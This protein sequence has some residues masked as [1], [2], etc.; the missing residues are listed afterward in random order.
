MPERR[1]VTPEPI[2][3]IYFHKGMNSKRDGVNIDDGEVQ[4]AI[5]VTF[6]NPS[7]I[8]AI[9]TREA[10]STN[11]SITFH[12]LFRHLNW[13][14]ALSTDKLYYQWDLDGYCNRYVQPN[15]E[16]TLAGTIDSP[17]QASCVGYQ[18]FIFIANGTKMQAFTDGNVYD[19]QFINPTTAST[20]ANAGGGAIN[21][22]VGAMTGYYT[23]LIKYP[24]GHV[25]ETAPS[26]ASNALTSVS[27]YSINWTNIGIYPTIK[28]PTGCVVHR[29]LYRYNASIGGT[30][31]VAT[32]E[33]NTATTY[34]DNIDNT[35]LATASELTT[36]EVVPFPETATALA[37][38]LNRLFV[39]KDNELWWSEPYL[40]F[41]TK[42]GNTMK[43]CPNDEALTTVMEYAD[44]LYYASRKTWYK[45]SGTDP[46]T[47]SNKPTYADVGV[48]A[49]QSAKRTKY[50]II[51]VWYDG[52][53]IFNGVVTKA[54][55]KEKLASD[56]WWSTT[57][58]GLT[59]KP[60]AIAEYDGETYTLYQGITGAST[61]F[62]IQINTKFYPDITI[63]RDNLS[64]CALHYHAISTKYYMI[65]LWDRYA[66]THPAYNGILYYRNPLDAESLS[67]DLQ[68]LYLKS[69]AVIG[70]NPFKRKCAKYLYYDM[71][72][73]NKS[74]AI[75]IYV[76]AIGQ[77]AVTTGGQELY[78]T[79]VNTG[80]DG[81]TAIRKRGR[82]QLPDLEGYNFTVVIYNVTDARGIK[83]YQPWGLHTVLTGD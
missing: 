76:D 23:F 25:V 8:E 21:E 60:K 19:C 70:S 80:L 9:P 33:N 75:Q 38:H 26:P 20:L 2:D 11:P 56:D 36:E 48:V 68:Y 78:S 83:I 79:T 61:Q 45:L 74:V 39:V 46:D 12:T 28:I 16:F 51:H 72:T 40:P 24:N 53:Y 17:N 31:F 63:A 7:V 64:F 54:L 81:A 4:S 69:K 41:M 58:Y 30:H 37:L 49:T 22:A 59:D 71:N 5:G 13:L 29:N 47:W 6:S 50:G 73:N 77:E 14:I 27:S 32:I 82:I 15:R 67:T 10:V 44:I 52:I 43:V 55:T 62:G 57:D 42:L 35:T 1:G 65:S 34:W 66:A 18:D 3:P